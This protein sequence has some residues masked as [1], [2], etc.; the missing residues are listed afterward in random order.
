M[1]SVACTANSVTSRDEAFTVS[2]N[3]SLN[4]PELRLK[5]KDCSSGLRKSGKK[6]VTFNASGG[7]ILSTRLPLV[8]VIA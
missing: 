8:S 4:S 5:V 7:A 1:L 3:V 6:S 2:E